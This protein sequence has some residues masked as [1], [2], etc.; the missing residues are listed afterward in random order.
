MR[1][2]KIRANSERPFPGANYSL[3]SP[4]SM[5]PNKTRRREFS[6]ARLI[7]SFSC[8]NETMSIIF[9]VPPDQDSHAIHHHAIIAVSDSKAPRWRSQVA[10]RINTAPLHALVHAKFDTKIVENREGRCALIFC[11]ADDHFIFPPDGRKKSPGCLNAAY[12][13][14]SPG[15]FIS[16]QISVELNILLYHRGENMSN[17][18]ERRHRV[19]PNNCSKGL[20]LDL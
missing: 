16:M 7:V 3:A 6:S 18:F 13:R 14:P 12:E 8:S 2:R 1:I 9:S 15:N 10:V 11:T 19:S 17:T 5:R 20:I 4:I